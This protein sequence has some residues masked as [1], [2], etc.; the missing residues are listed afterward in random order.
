MKKWPVASCGFAT[1]RSRRKDWGPIATAQLY[2]TAGY[3]IVSFVRALPVKE[4]ALPSAMTEHRVLLHG[5]DCKHEEGWVSGRAGTNSTEP[6]AEGRHSRQNVNG[7]KH[8]P[9]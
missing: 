3:Q 9:R 6:T 5:A 7:D 4:D 2:G 1:G 8:H